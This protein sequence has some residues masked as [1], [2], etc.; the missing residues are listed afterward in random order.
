[1]PQ[2]TAQTTDSAADRP[3]IIIGVPMELARRLL[4]ELDYAMG[5]S[6]WD[7]TPIDDLTR[8]LRMA[9][10]DHHRTKAN[11]IVDATKMPEHTSSDEDRLLAAAIRVGY[12]RAHGIPTTLDTERSL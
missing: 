6:T 9:Y 4:E 7:E 1:M 2:I 10:Q 3:T 11:A 12:L 8:Q 5:D